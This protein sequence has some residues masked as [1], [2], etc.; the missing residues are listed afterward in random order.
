M[1]REQTHIGCIDGKTIVVRRQ[2]GEV[3]LNIGRAEAR[4]SKEATTRL[5][6]LLSTTK[7]PPRRSNKREYV[8][9]AVKRRRDHET[10]TD[11]MTENLISSGTVFVLTEE[12][13]DHFALI[14]EDGLI[15]IEGHTERTPS[16]ACEWVIG[17]PCSGWE[18]WRVPGENSLAAL[19]WILRAKQFPD[20]DHGYAHST[21]R[22]KNS[23]AMEWVDYALTRGY[24]PGEYNESQV[25]G[26]LIDRQLKNDCH[27]T[28]STLKVYRGHLRQWFNYYGASVMDVDSKPE[29]APWMKEESDERS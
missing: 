26:Y 2:R 5:V 6:N 29:V 24:D 11:L 27:Y 25:E 7:Y 4:L 17:R 19:R 21:T 3:I 13:V 14:T 1:N 23:I 15:D 20:K 10:I 9:P 8:K 28:A 22:E 16:G 18:R 12:G